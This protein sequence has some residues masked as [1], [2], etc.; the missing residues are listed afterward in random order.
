[1]NEKLS[2]VKRTF[3]ISIVGLVTATVL[4][5]TGTLLVAN[6]VGYDNRVS[7]TAI[8]DLT[9]DYPEVR[10]YL[11]SQKAAEPHFETIATLVKQEQERRLGEIILLAALP[12]IVVSGI[13]G[14]ILAR[15][16]L[17]PVSES[18]EAQ[19]RF[20]QDAAHELRNPLAAMSATI[21]AS[22]VNKQKPDKQKLVERLE[23]QTKRLININEDLL[24]LQ[25]AP[26]AYASKSTNITELTHKVVG[27]LRMFAEDAKITLTTSIADDTVI[28]I[29]GRDYEIVVRNLIENAIKYSLENSTVAIR[30]SRKSKSAILEV[31][32]YGI[33]IPEKDLHQITKRFYR[34]SNI[35]EIHGSG[36]GLA[37]VQ[38]VVDTYNARLSIQSNVGSGTTMRITFNR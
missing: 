20:I 2:R 35:G 38:K 7:G 13:I 5:L 36:L 9:T 26:E 24:Y 28:K 30:L 16:L 31:Q 10:A 29:V 22:K 12:I 33:G 32:D 21:E 17:E 15:R 34:A 18:Y 11:Q 6:I 4:V 14:Y 25:R 23:R 1:M 8:T 3:I 27:E 37:L 19:E